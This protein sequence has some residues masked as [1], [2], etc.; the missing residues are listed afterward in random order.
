M[1][2][3]S[4]NSSNNSAS[5]A[6]NL[7]LPQF[8]QIARSLQTS[9][10]LHIVISCGPGEEAQATQL[11]QLLDRYPHTLYISK[12]GLRCFA[13]HLQFA[14]LFISGSTGPLHIASLRWQTLNSEEYR[15]VFSPAETAAEEDMS[16]INVED[17]A[18]Q[19][20]EKF[21]I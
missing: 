16:S 21:L 3:M 18:K 9:T 1:L 11:S 19:I 12:D 4:V 20:S 5:S 13:E 6:A 7:S 17:A 10:N 8:A 14:D 2:S 15:L